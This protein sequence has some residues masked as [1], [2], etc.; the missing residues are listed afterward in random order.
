MP[1]NSEVEDRKKRE[2]IQIHFWN[3]VG[4]VEH[5]NL[6][7]LQDAIRKEFKTDDDRFIQ[8]QINLMQTEAKIKVQRKNKVW[9]KEPQT[10]HE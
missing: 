8:T 4:A 2:K 5:I 7:K 10:K 1:K 6:P 9:I 3:V